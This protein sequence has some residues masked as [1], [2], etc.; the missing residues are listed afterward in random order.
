MDEQENLVSVSHDLWE[1]CIVNSVVELAG[2][3]FVVCFP[4]KFERLRNRTDIQGD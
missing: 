3:M 4:L 2:L 1:G